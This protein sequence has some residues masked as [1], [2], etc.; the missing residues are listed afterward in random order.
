MAIFVVMMTWG[1]SPPNRSLEGEPCKDGKCVGTDVCYTKTNTCVHA[2]SPCNPD[3]CDHGVCSA[4]GNCTCSDGWSGDA[5]DVP[6]DPCTGINCGDHGTC[7]DGTCVCHDNYTG[8]FCENPPVDPC[9]TDPCADE[10]RVCVADNGSASCGD[11][12]AGYHEEASDCVED[13]TCGLNTCSGH[14]TCDDSSGS[15]VCDCDEEY[16]GDHCE[17]CNTGYHAVGDD[18]VE[19]EVCQPDSCSGHGTCSTPSGVIECACD[20][21]Y[22]GDI[23]NECA[24][25]YHLEGQNCV[26]DEVCQPDSCSGHGTCSTPSG[27]I[28]CA[29]D[30]GYAG[31]I[32]NECAAGYHLEGQECVADDCEIDDNCSNDL[33]CDGAETCGPEHT[34]QVGTDPCPGEMCREDDDQCVECLADGNCDNGDFCDGA[35]TCDGNGDC[36]S[37]SDPCPGEMCSEAD[38]QCV[39]CLADGDC[40]DNLAC[41]GTETCVGGTCEPGTPETCSGHGDCQEPDASCDCDTGWSGDYCDVEIPLITASLMNEV[42]FLSL[43]N[44]LNF[45]YH[46]GLTATED[47]QTN[48]HEITFDFRDQADQP[49]G[50]ITVDDVMYYRGRNELLTGPNPP[51]EVTVSWDNTQLTVD[52]IAPEP[53]QNEVLQDYFL[54]II[55]SGVSVGDTLTTELVNVRLEDETDVPI[56]GVPFTLPE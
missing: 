35:E 29:C 16:A 46:F 9:D 32:C 6:A 49:A 40:D 12:L 7:S 53:L 23:C 20:A 45:V 21:G 8:E 14:G 50:S 39:E 31:D 30:A 22:A 18:C 36:Q 34:C 26:E 37:G 41:T 48:R 33:F 27:V 54:G 42:S 2:D 56:S 28:E 52:F 15:P 44:G 55:V 3:P 19:D 5:C 51:P 11:C 47:L 10:H 17:A 25:G 38:N 4:D 13:V 24:P 1:C 43:S